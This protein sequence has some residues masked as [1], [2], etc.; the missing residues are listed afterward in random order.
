M[1]ASSDSPHQQSGSP[2]PVQLDAKSRIS[3]TEQALMNDFL[4]IY[5]SPKPRIISPGS[6]HAALVT[7]RYSCDYGAGLLRLDTDASL[8][9]KNGKIPFA[10]IPIIGLDAEIVEELS[11]TYKLLEFTVFREICPLL[12]MLLDRHFYYDF[13]KILLALCGSDSEIEAAS[14]GTIELLISSGMMRSSRPS[15]LLDLRRNLENHR[16]RTYRDHEKQVPAKRRINEVLSLLEQSQQEDGTFLTTNL[17]QDC[18]ESLKSLVIVHFEVVWTVLSHSQAFISSVAGNMGFL[19]P[20]LGRTKVDSVGV[21]D[22]WQLPCEHPL[23]E[24]VMSTTKL[25]MG[26]LW[27]TQDALHVQAGSCRVFEPVLSGHVRHGRGR[28]FP[29]HVRI[30]QLLNVSGRLLLFDG[31]TSKRVCLADE[32][33]LERLKKG[34]VRPRLLLILKRTLE[35]LFLKVVKKFLNIARGNADRVSEKLEITAVIEGMLVPGVGILCFLVKLRAP[36]VEDRIW[37][38]LNEDA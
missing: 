11:A 28:I 7:S 29:S 1:E 17:E 25:L 16:K 22:W 21:E 38:Y 14:D 33:L 12:Q 5:G 32:Q 30:A 34:L 20:F 19:K 35:E 24:P 36:S 2:K 3:E 6:V 9:G 27:N 31:F 37:R 26:I 4:S 15:R 23:L 10:I 18:I 8:E 13:D